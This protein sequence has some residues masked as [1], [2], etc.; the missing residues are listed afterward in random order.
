MT[1]N[2]FRKLPQVT[3]VLDAP[4]L[5]AAR[6]AHPPDAVADAVRAELDAVRVR[7]ASG[8]AN[9]VPS[10]DELAVSATAVNN[11]AA[12]TVIVLRALAHGKEVVVSRGQLIEIGGSFRIPEIMAVSGGTLPEVG[13]P[14]ITRGG[15]YEKAIGPNTGLLM[16]VHTS[17]YRVRGFTK[18]VSLEDL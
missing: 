13:T 16:R 7:L 10:A 6:A 15:D 14:N 1:D 11:C 17:N 18:A 3:K 4:A 5:A 12:A 2:P 8:E 9:G